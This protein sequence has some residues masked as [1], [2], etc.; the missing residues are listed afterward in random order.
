MMELKGEDTMGRAFVSINTDLVN[1]PKYRSLGTTGWFLY[2]LYEQRQQVSQYHSLNG[3]KTFTDNNGAFIYFSNEEA[4]DILGVSLRKL[5]QLRKQLIECGLI[6]VVRHGLRNFKIYVNQPELTPDDVELKMK[7]SNFSFE[8][9]E[10]AQNVDT[11]LVANNASDYSQNMPINQSNNNQSKSNITR[12]TNETDTPAQKSGVQPVSQPTEQDLDDMAIK[13]LEDKVAP[14]LTKSTFGRIKTLSQGSYSKAKWFVD[15][16]F[17]AKSQ[18]ES[19]LLS[20]D[21]WLYSPVSSEATRFETNELLSKG[22]ESALLQI[23]EHVY[24]GKETIRNAS[25]FIY[26]YIRNFMASAVRN[27]IKDNYELVEDDEIELNMLMN[28]KTPA[29]FVA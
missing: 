25:S 10:M 14:V 1:N 20:S 6:K 15:T 3:D 13:S 16:I 26:V 7:W 21:T 8:K 9:K 4:A 23:A 28:F 2:S 19:K 29:A 24:R 12:E 22:L 18:V 11:T 27:Y 5:T 17:K